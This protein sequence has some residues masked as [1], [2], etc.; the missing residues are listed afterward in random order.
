MN[1]FLSH[2]RGDYNL[3]PWLLSV[4][5]PAILAALMLPLEMFL[6]PTNTELHFAESL[7][8]L[9]DLQL[10]NV[11]YLPISYRSYVQQAFC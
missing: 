2:A 4:F 11:R 8:V 10:K 9:K 7:L 1:A 6:F 5:F 3:E